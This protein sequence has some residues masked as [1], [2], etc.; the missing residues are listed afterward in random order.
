MDNG[1]APL[2]IYCI[3][4]QKMRVSDD[5]YGR[6]GKC[7]ACR[8]KLRIPHLDEI[9]K[10]TTEIRLSEHPEFLRDPDQG[11][12][13]E[14]VTPDETGE[15]PLVDTNGDAGA[16]DDE[17]AERGAI[18]M[19]VLPLLRTLASFDATLERAPRDAGDEGTVAKRRQRVERLRA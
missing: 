19:D 18:P 7:V 6:P 8:R 14:A 1:L 17:A 15:A 12:P 5:M 16:S 10:G 11:T 9:P 4:G 13:D 2:R 3:C